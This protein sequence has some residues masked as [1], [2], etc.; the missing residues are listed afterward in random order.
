MGGGRGWQA[1]VGVSYAAAALI[2]W[3]YDHVLLT[4]QWSHAAFMA[5]GLVFIGLGL[6][7]LA[8]PWAGS[9][10]ASKQAGALRWDGQAWWC[11]E[12]SAANRVSVAI[13][14]GLDDIV[15]LCLRELGLSLSSGSLRLP[16]YVML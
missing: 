10:S 6:S 12:A 3:L 8:G 16:R 1:L 2:T 7:A 5:L 14:M 11:C 13:A 4:L 15:L 9:C